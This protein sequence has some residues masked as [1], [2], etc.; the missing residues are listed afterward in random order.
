MALS[1]GLRF[2]FSALA[3]ERKNVCAGKLDCYGTCVRLLRCESSSSVAAVAIIAAM[4]VVPPVAPT[5]PRQSGTLVVAGVRTFVYRANG[6]L[7]GWVRRD[8]PRMWWASDGY[9]SEVFADKKGGYGIT[10]GFHTYGNAWP[11]PPGQ[12]S[13]Y[14]VAGSNTWFVRITAAR[15]NIMRR[16]RLVAFTKGPDGVAAALAFYMWG[17]GILPR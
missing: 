8:A 10:E 5:A 3:S 2:F 9:N 13:R 1:P 14:R 17:D 16:G 11:S 15:W 12:R 4:L 7:V 6:R